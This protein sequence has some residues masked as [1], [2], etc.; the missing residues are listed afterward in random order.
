MCVWPAFIDPAL[1]IIF[2]RIWLTGSGRAWWTIID[3][4]SD[5]GNDG[6]GKLAAS[7]NDKA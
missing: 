3:G 6:E 1:M 2:G 7:V 4:V 5:R